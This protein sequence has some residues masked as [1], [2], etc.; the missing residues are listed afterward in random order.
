MSVEGPDERPHTVTTIKCSG[1][2]ELQ[3]LN[4]ATFFM[5]TK[6]GHYLERI[7]FDEHM[8]NDSVI[9]ADQIFTE[10]IALNSCLEKYKAP[11]D[12]KNQPQGQLLHWSQP[13]MYLH[14]DL[15][16]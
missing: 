5:Y 16:Q 6:G 14:R 7:Y 3:V 11:A 9:A 4:G 12:L 15:L 2:W 1:K 13:R 10:F 8:W